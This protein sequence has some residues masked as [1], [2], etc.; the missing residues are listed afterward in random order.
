MQIVY[1]E[2]KCF[3]G[4]ARRLRNLNEKTGAENILAALKRK[5]VMLEDELKFDPEDIQN[6]P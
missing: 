3:E 1:E 5:L 2:I 6:R 4:I